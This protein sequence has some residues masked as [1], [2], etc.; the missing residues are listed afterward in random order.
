MGTNFYLYEEKACPTCGHCKEPRHIG[1]SSAGWCFSLHVYPEEG[2]N[3]FADWRAL[4][5]N[6]DYL[7]QD[8]Y[9]DI[10]SREE[11]LERIEERSWERKG[12]ST[13]NYAANS[14]EKGP[15]GLVRHKI[16]GRR[17]IGHGEG[18][19]DYMIGDFS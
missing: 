2:I 17:C 8:E 11:L 13:F 9:G 3:S 14:A 16:D 19:Y 6:P 12:D 10:I 18:T 4:I 5:S 15:N 1:K 7:I